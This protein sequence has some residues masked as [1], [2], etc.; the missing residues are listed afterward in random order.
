MD[1]RLSRERHPSRIVTLADGT[2]ILIRPIRVAD[3]AAVRQWFRGLSAD[4]RYQRFHA[5]VADLSDAHWQYL[6]NV[7]GVDHVALLATVHGRIVGVGRL[8][9]RPGE[10]EVAFLVDDLYQRRGV[11]SALR[12]ELIAAAHARGARR[13][14]AHVLPLNVGIRRLLTAPA[15]QL[16]AD[17]GDLLELVIAD[18]S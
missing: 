9:I 4:A 15:L 2:T 16:I 17:R 7:N 1:L 10:G 8:I 14:C 12:D 3:S 5:H 11:G 6:L 13:L 18:A